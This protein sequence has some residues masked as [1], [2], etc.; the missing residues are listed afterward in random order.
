MELI[1]LF[2]HFTEAIALLILN[3][4]IKQVVHLTTLIIWLQRHIQII[5]HKYQHVTYRY[6]VALSS[7]T[8]EL[9]LIYTCEQNIALKRFNFVLLDV[10]SILILEP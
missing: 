7:C 9:K 8:L 10:F 4:T 5:E 3:L 6:Q 2:Y 1:Q